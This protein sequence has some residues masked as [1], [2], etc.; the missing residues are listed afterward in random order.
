MGMPS[1]SSVANASASAWPQ[2]IPPSWT[3]R[4]PTIELLRELGVDG[5]ALG[6]AQ[7]LLVE[8]EEPLLGNRGHD[9][10]SLGPGRP[11]GTGPAGGRAL[12]DAVTETFVGLPQGCGDALHEGVGLLG[13]QHALV[14]QARRV[15]LAR[16]RLQLDLLHH[17]RLGVR[18]LVLLVVP[19]AAVA[20]EVDHEVVAELL[21]VGERQTDG[22]ERRFG[23]VR[24][25]VDDRDVEALRE[26]A[27]VPGRAALRRIRREPDLVVRDHVERSARRV[28]VQALQVERLGDDTLA[29]E[30]GV[31]VDEDRE[32]HRRV[33]ETRA[34]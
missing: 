20:H 19:E 7:Q 22:A 25:D 6:D 13:R 8:R 18:R 27:R 17:Q 15:A 16:R 30:R 9:P 34:T 10:V 5:E 2:S 4:A 14:D 12:T 11:T 31:A 21:A 32:R 33:V 24:V 28:P 1:S 23:I 26:I 29:R 3:L